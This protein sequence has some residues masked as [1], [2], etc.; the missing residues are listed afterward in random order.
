MHAGLEAGDVDLV[1]LYEL[2]EGAPVLLCH[3]GRT[4]DVTFAR[5]KQSLNVV[6]FKTSNLFG[7]C[8]SQRLL[9]ATASRRRD[10]EVVR[11]KYRTFAKHHGPLYHVL[12]LTH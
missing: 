5:G 3:L 9:L 8:L 11:L 1:F 4:C 12:Q 10:N 6:A 7:L 2:P